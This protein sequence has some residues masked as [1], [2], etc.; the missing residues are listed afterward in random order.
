VVQHTRSIP[1]RRA[2]CHASTASTNILGDFPNHSRVQCGD[3]RCAFHAHRPWKVPATTMRRVTCTHYAPPLS[4]KRHMQHRLD[5]TWQTGR[6]RCTAPGAAAVDQSDSAHDL[7]ASSRDQCTAAKG[8][9]PN[10][11][12]AAPATDPHHAQLR[13]GIMRAS[14]NATRTAIKMIRLPAWGDCLERT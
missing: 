5:Q 13:T 1:A 4:R 10:H 9:C 11:A 2:P 8:I 6:G 7:R 12:P 3:L 14:N